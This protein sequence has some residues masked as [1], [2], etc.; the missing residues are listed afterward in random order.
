MLA[1]HLFSHV[2][3]QKSLVS[4]AFNSSGLIFILFLK[5]T[6]KSRVEGGKTAIQPIYG[7]H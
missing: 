7:V 3:N 2:S 1:P 4:T 6:I 5:A